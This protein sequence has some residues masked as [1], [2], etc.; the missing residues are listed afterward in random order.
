[1]S[2]M[3]KP[4]DILLNKLVATGTLEI[5]TSTGVLHRYGDGVPPRVAVRL[6]DRRMSASH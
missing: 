3:F 1:M 6:G 5:E 2:A 4:L